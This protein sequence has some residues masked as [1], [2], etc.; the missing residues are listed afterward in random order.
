M[1]AAKRLQR[2]EEWPL[3]RAK[4]LSFIARFPRAG[5]AN[6]RVSSRSG[7]LPGNLYP[8]YAAR[9]GKQTLLDK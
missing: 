3:E 8:S 9:P 4:T 7:D 2:K 1:R 5:M 6:E